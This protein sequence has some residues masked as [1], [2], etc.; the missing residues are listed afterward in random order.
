MKK[1]LL[2]LMSLLVLSGCA[3][4]N[5]DDVVSE[6]QFTLY[7]SYYSAVLANAKFMEGSSFYNISYELVEEANET[8]YYIFID[9]P[10]VAM[11]D[12][13]I[14][15]LEGLNELSVDKMMPTFGIFDSQ[16]YNMVPYQVNVELGYVEGIV[17]SGAVSEFDEPLYVMITWKDFS[18]LETYREY[19]IVD[20]LNLEQVPEVEEVE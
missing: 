19:L 9:N 5:A 2:V 4:N 3:F 7:S 11:Y 10:N 8:V 16:V 15:V 12:I 17:V 20:P 13:D 6:E 18:K 14:L 1:L